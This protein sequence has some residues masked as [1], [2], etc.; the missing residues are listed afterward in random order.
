MC[1]CLV[2]FFS[3]YRLSST[4]ASATTFLCPQHGPHPRVRATTPHRSAGI[5]VRPAE[6][7]P[8]TARA[9]RTAFLLNYSTS[10]DVTCKSVRRGSWRQVVACTVT[11][12]SLRTPLPRT[13]NRVFSRA[14]PLPAE[15]CRIMLQ[16]SSSISRW[17][18]AQHAGAR[19]LHYLAQDACACRASACFHIRLRPAEAPHLAPP[20]T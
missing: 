20:P 2:A 17:N 4:F 3:D 1:G 13:A 10:H 15:S 6:P 5:R 7:K 19:T 8:L 16:I 18:V 9:G 11:K 12:S 14:C